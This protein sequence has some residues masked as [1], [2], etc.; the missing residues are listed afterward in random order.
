ML[1]YRSNKIQWRNKFINVYQYII[2]VTSIQ[3][4]IYIVRCNIVVSARTNRRS[5]NI[6]RRRIHS[7]KK[8]LWGSQRTA[9]P[10]IRQQREESRY[11]TR[12]RVFSPAHYRR[13]RPC[14]KLSF[15]RP[16]MR[17]V[18]ASKCQGSRLSGIA[19]KPSHTPALQFPSSQ[20]ILA[21]TYRY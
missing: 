5:Q 15:T 21:K 19:D 7:T 4:E 17:N 6:S 3:L 2:Y 8:I 18:S 16:D 1:F 9:I 13:H 10:F 12:V 11:N 20:N 14:S